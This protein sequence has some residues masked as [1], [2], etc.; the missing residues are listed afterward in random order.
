MNHDDPRKNA[1]EYASRRASDNKDRMAIKSGVCAWSD[2][3]FSTI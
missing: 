1:E 3:F 2:D